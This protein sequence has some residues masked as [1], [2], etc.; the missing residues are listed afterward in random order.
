MTYG[1]FSSCVIDDADTHRSKVRV[2]VHDLEEGEV[3]NYGCTANTVT[4]QG[5]VMFEN[6]K[7]PLKRDS[8]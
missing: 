4:P 1:E 5:N 6:W 7:L 3:R 2:L 8:E